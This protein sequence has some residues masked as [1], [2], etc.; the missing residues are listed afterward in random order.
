[1]R[2]RGYGLL[3]ETPLWGWGMWTADSRALC[4]PLPKEGKSPL[5]SP[6]AVSAHSASE[7][8]SYAPAGVFSASSGSP[9]KSAPVASSGSIG[10][11]C[12]SPGFTTLSARCNSIRRFPLLRRAAN[13]IPILLRASMFSRICLD[14]FFGVSP[15]VPSGSIFLESSV[16]VP[17]NSLSKRSSSEIRN[18]TRVFSTPSRILSSSA[19]HN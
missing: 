16:G 4:L 7:V 13:E 11:I 8:P 19:C 9:R 17:I 3:P 12:E 15:S 10:T 18:T 6:S 5:E 14:T 1:M 2:R